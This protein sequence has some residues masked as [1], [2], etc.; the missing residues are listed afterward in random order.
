MK[1][2]FEREFCHIH[3]L[4][5]KSRINNLHTD[6]WIVGNTLVFGNESGKNNLLFDRVSNPYLNIEWES[7]L[8]RQLTK[9]RINAISEYDKI[10]IASKFNNES[11]LF[12]YFQFASELILEEIRQNLFPNKP[13]R[14][15]AIWL[16]DKKDIEI[17][18][19]KIP[20]TIYPQK[21]F[22]VKF[23]GIYHKADSKW[24]TETSLNLESI[25]KNSIEYW[26]G[27]IYMDNRQ[28]TFEY[29]CDGKIIIVDEL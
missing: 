14:T 27:N 8:I 3:T 2:V 11:F 21:I 5:D 24:I 29:T 25:Y 26:K 18:K 22:V 9:D 10:E 23:T 7:K 15:N 13:S 19:S 28:P 17:W 4:Q 12:R 16:C 6:K 1:E 20:A